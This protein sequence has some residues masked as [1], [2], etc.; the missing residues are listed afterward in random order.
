MTTSGAIP[1]NCFAWRC[2]SNMLKAGR[3]LLESL[4]A[5]LFPPRCALCARELPALEIVCSDCVSS[6]PSFEG[7]LCLH[8]GEPVDDPLIDLCFRCGT[9]LLAVD[10]VISLG[11]YRGAWG[12]LVRSFKFE[13]EIA[14]GRWLG[15]R[16]AAALLARNMVCEFSAITFVP[17]TRRDRRERGFN[18]AE[19]LAR[20]IA[21]QLNLPLIR[22]LAKTCETPLQ[23]G[24]SARERKTNLRDAFRLLPCRQEQVLLVDDIYTTGSTVEECARTLKRGSAQSVVAITVAR[25]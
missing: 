1:T 15:E 17:M 8:C 2:S 21:R 12:H 18:Q 5:A 19:V 6:L 13:R 16:M 3:R 25:A 23:S 10:H 20:V 9:K 11:P 4:A 7:S 24:L 14:I 22:G